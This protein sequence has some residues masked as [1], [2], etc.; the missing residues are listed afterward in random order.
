[1]SDV[2]ELKE[3][4]ERSWTDVSEDPSAPIDAP[5][6]EATIE[7]LDGGSVRVAEPDGGRDGSWHVNA[8]VRQAV[9]LYFRVRGLETSEVGPFEYHDKLP[10]KH[11]YEAQGV[12]VV[13]Q[14]TPAPGLGTP[15]RRRRI[16]AA[17][18]LGLLRGRGRQ[19]PRSP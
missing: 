15:P 19:V 12:R 10:L 3:R 13:P 11:G 18:S 8:W 4:I 17:E 2:Q 7:L 16:P 5:A 6:V 9:L 1:M 14:E